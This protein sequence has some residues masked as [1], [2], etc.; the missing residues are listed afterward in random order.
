MIHLSPALW[1]IH[2]GHYLR[3]FRWTRGATDPARTIY[4][5]IGNFQ[6]VGQLWGLSTR[7]ESK[8]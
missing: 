7:Q 4:T 2:Q 3:H 8:Q 1:V 5:N 6:F